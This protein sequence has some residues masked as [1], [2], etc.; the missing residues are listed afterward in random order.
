MS[1][2]KESTTKKV[3]EVLDEND[4]IDQL[5]DT[6]LIKKILIKTDEERV[7]QLFDDEFIKKMLGKDDELLKKVLLSKGKDFI[8]NLLNDLQKEL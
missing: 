3:K 7:N 8:Q 2:K 6:K 4:C 1:F 5:F